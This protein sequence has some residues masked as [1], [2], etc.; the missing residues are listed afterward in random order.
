MDGTSRHRLALERLLAA[1]RHASCRA[2]LSERGIDGA[3]RVEDSDRRRGDRGGRGGRARGPL[4]APAPVTRDGCACVRA[5]RRRVRVRVSAS[6]LRAPR[7]ASDLAAQALRSRRTGPSNPGRG[8]RAARGRALQPAMRT[9]LQHVALRGGAHADRRRHRRDVPHDGGAP[10]GR[11]VQDHGREPLL[12]PDITGALHA[13]RRS[14]ISGTVRLF[15]NG[16]LLHRMGDDFWE[17]LDE[18]TISNYASAPVKPVVLQA[19]RD[20]A[21]FLRR[22]AQR[23]AG[24][25]VQRGDARRAPGLRRRRP[26][27]VRGML[28]EAPVSRRARRQVL[29]VHARRVCNGLPPRAAARRLPRGPGPRARRRRPSDDARPRRGPARVPQPHRAA[30]VLPLLPRGAGPVAPHAQ[31]SRADVRAGRLRPLRVLPS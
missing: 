6:D 22:R 8:V 30:R 13:I 26:A 10:R 3:F 28:A 23:Q 29:H 4:A 18:L 16:L 12:H 11:R 21:G 19:A 27:D 20:K 25:R 31:L 7:H 24:R 2:Q 15:T 9:L 14:G 1:L 5:E 17:A